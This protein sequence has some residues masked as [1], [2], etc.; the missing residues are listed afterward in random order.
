MKREGID[1]KCS[2]C[3]ASEVK[4]TG[5][6]SDDFLLAI[7]ASIRY[8]FSEW[9]YHSKLGDGT[10]EGLFFIEPNLILKI[11]P[12]QSAVDR[13][14]VILSFL[15]DVNHRQMQ[16]E[17]FTAYGRDIYNYSP[18]TAI[19]EGESAILRNARQAL[20]EKNYFLV[21]DEYENILS[22]VIRSI[23]TTVKAGTRWYRAR[24]GATEAAANF[25]EMGRPP[26]YFYEGHKDKS[27]GAP[28]VGA[29]AAGRVNRPGVSY[30]YLAS[31]LDTAAAEIRP[32]P[33]EL[34]SLGCFD[35]TK[36]LN[37]VDL[38]TNHLTKLWR[39]D[40]EL[41]M[42]ELVVAMEKIFSTAAPPSNRSTY[43]VTQFLGELVRRLGFDGV[44][45]RSTV[46][47]GENLVLFD[48]A[49]ASWVNESSKVVRVRS[50]K[51]VIDPVQLFDEAKEYDIDHKRNAKRGY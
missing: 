44:K 29:S 41:E 10:L 9:Q 15:E 36:D 38:T 2:L 3:N 8:H 33:G 28:P 40:E 35:V 7:K 11:N 18:H 39:T 6:G 48:P 50:V 47:T 21:E 43:T 42:L 46:E 24:M 23:S 45:F 16:V 27:I 13:E 5:T 19:S 51:Y 25:T 26:T 14:D 31:T 30:L 12:S 17:V 4:C 22:P 20:T 32:H 34:V 1:A 49:H 37:I